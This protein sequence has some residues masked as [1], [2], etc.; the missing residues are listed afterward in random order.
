MKRTQRAQR[1]RVRRG[2]PDFLDEIIAE[3]TKS[4]PQFSQLVDA[5]YERRELL[6]QLVNARLRA[7]LTQAQVAERMGT[8]QAAVARIESGDFDLRTTTLDRYAL[9]VGRRINYRLSAAS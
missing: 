1:K 7:E 5:A 4:D 6:N 8:S 3:G 9:A 2:R